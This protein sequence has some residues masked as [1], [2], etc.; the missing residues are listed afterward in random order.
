MSERYSFPGEGRKLPDR[1]VEQAKIDRLTAEYLEA[2]KEIYQAVQ[3]ETA[4]NPSRR[5]GF[6]Q[7]KRPTGP[8]A[9]TV[10]KRMGL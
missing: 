9:A 3:G 2:G 1:E 8:K 6:Q 5:K 10:K 4:F 7:P